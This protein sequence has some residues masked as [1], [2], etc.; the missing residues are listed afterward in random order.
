VAAVNAAPLSLASSEHSRFA[1]RFGV[2]GRTFEAGSYPV[3]QNRWLTAEYFRV[4]GIP[5]KRGRLLLESDGA[6]ANI[7]VNETLARRFFPHADPVGQQLIFGVMDPQQQR[8]EIVGVV[9]DVREMGLEQ[10]VEPTVYGITTTAVM[11]LLVK[12][13]SASPEMARVLRDAIH[14]ADPEI[15]AGRIQP[16][17]QNVAD[18][19]ERRRLALVLLA[20]FGGIA[21]VLT[22]AGIYGLMAQSVN[23]RVR[24]LGVRAAI[25]AAPRE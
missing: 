8:G 13:A 10:E 20:I 2:P 3:A 19:L 18:S 4:L 5:L 25:G 12:T 21:A 23:A 11:T 14:G 1:T 22:A 16:L 6:T 24:E 15:A 9:S 7:L 17:E